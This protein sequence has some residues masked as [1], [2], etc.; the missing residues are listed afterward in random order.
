MSVPVFAQDV[1]NIEYSPRIPQ[2]SNYLKV[3]SKNKRQREFDKLFLSQ[4]LKWKPDNTS[5]PAPARISSK[6]EKGV[7]DAIWAMSFSLDGRYLAAGGEN[8]LIKI[9]SVISSEEERDAQEAEEMDYA[10]DSPVH[11]RASVFQSTPI[12]VYTEHEGPILDLQ[13]SKVIFTILASII[14][15]TLNRTTFFLQLPRTELYVY[16]ILQG[17]NACALSNIPP[18]FLQLPFTQKTIDFS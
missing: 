3:R 13:W 1:D 15:L 17:Q 14:L 18:Q 11:M 10:D 9:W 2:P 6:G 12:R 4:E 16:F 5:R 7:Q 8:K